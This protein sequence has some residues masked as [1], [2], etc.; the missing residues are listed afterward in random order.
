MRA[1]GVGHDGNFTT[2][3]DGRTLLTFTAARHHG[4]AVFASEFK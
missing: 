4:R 3:C 1:D 2:E